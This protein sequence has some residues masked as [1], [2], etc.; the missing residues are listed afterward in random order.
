MFL[1]KPKV[2]AITIASAFIGLFFLFCLGWAILDHY[3]KG[4][5]DK[6]VIEETAIKKNDFPDDFTVVA[7][8]DS[9]TRG[10]GDETGKGYVGLVI[11][12][13]KSEYN[14][15]PII[16]NLGI[17]G[18]VSK[19]LVQQ[20]RQPEVKRQIQ[21]ADVILVTIGGNDLFQKGRTLLE[22]DRDAITVSQKNF[23]GNL[24]EIFK[25][26]N[27]VNDTA[28]ILLLGL[29]NPFI[30]LDEDFDTNRIVR[31]WNNETAEVVALYEN[32][33]FVP[34]FDLFQ[35]SVNEYLYS[36]KFHPNKK[37]YRLIADRVAPLIKWEDV[38]R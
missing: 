33:I 31:D 30:D 14:R 9:L 4:T 34:T 22:Y 11:E 18:Q 16:H 2:L 8:G 38:E 21:A 20:V 23:L 13:L 29:Y 36:D 12:D 35:L 26:I 3:G 37:G 6:E 27:K 19:E 25:D 1:S 24:H 5:S 32:A 28:T 10:T 15:K 17:N 7:I